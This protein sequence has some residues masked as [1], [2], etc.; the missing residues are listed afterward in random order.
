MNLAGDRRRNSYKEQRAFYTS[1]A[2][3]HGLKTQVIMLPNGMAG[4]A[5][6]HSIAQNDR[7][8]FNLTGIEEYV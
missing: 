1:N 5:T 6:I 3:K 2:K 4:H 7:G 8:L